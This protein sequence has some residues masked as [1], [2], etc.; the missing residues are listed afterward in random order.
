MNKNEP[1]PPLEITGNS[2][3][4]GR[5][6]SGICGARNA[7]EK[8]LV[9]ARRAAEVVAECG[10]GLV[11]GDARGVDTEAEIGTLSHDGGGALVLSTG[12]GNWKPRVAIRPSVTQD[13]L[14]AVSQFP[15]NA[16]WAVH[17]SMKRNEVI[18]GL[19]E[20]LL[21]VEVG[22]NGGTMDAGLKCLR[23]D[24]PLLVVRTS[25]PTTPGNLELIRRGGTPVASMNE[26]R[27]RLEE[28]RDDRFRS[29]QGSLAM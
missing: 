11:T 14:V 1:L 8:A 23:Y 9:I 4:V 22:E 19:S 24:K 5:P 26:L 16:G 2:A 18:I 6:A 10:F 15:T 28:I 3:L 7:S 29:G 21:V 20:A 17:H 13:N 27:E 12:I 25:E